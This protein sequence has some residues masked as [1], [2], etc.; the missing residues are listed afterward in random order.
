MQ[1]LT[2]VPTFHSLGYWVK[3]F[4]ST[5][6]KL[7]REIGATQLLFLKGGE[8]FVFSKKIQKYKMKLKKVRQL[9]KSN[10]HLA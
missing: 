1:N 6:L 2:A 4:W 7:K 8:A 5:A 3:F 10:I 9:F